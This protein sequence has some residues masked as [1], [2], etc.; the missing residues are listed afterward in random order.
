MKQ[1]DSYKPSVIPWVSAIPSHWEEKRLRFICDYQKGKNPDVLCFEPEDG[2]LPYLSMEYIRET[3]EV[4]QYARPSDSSITCKNGDII[5]LWDGSNAGEFLKS[6]SGI[7]CSTCAVIFS[8]GAD[9]NFLWY[10]CK[11]A[12]QY[13][14]DM[15]N[16]MGVPH[17]DAEVLKNL[18]VNL[19]PIVEQEAIASYLDK[20]CGS[21]DKVIATQE[22]RVAL[23]SELKQNVITEAVT[24]GLDCNV[25]L[26]DSGID[27]IGRIPEHWQVMK[28]SHLYNSIGSGTTPSTDNKDYYDEDGCNWLQTGDLNDGYITETSRHISEVAL[29]TLNMRKYPIDSLVVAMYGATV[30]KLG[31]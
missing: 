17:V 27:W 16:G 5:L 19:P 20:K 25:P 11:T 14:K 15:T 18:R 29:R 31:L 24:F 21:I 3:S 26:K 2:M 22:Q 23:L 9:H 10:W 7:L 8:K 13:L 1:Y 12:Q 6:K 30:G 28:I 4:I